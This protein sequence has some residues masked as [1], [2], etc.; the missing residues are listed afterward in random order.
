MPTRPTAPHSPIGK[1]DDFA[2]AGG[3]TSTTVPFELINNHIYVDAQ[4][5]G[6]PL[7]LLFD[8]GGANVVT[9]TTAE[10]G[11]RAGDLIVALD[12]RSARDLSLLDARQRL[13]DAPGTRVRMTVRSGEA[14]REVTV[15]LRDLV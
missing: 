8:S 4:I 11:L 1:T 13:K 7:K 2:I 6:R 15:V 9:R 5:D 12:G 14:T 3:K 10:A